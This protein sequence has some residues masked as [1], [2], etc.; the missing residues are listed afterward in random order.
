MFL[1][2]AFQPSSHAAKFI[3]FAVG[4]FFM[5]RPIKNIVRLQSQLQQA[6]AASQRVLNCSK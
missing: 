3:P 1:Y 5:Y 4:V 2:F 6:R